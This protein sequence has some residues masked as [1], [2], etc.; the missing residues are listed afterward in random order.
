MK[1]KRTPKYLRGSSKHDGRY[2]DFVEHCRYGKKPHYTGL[3]VEADLLTGNCYLHWHSPVECRIAGTAI[4][5]DITHQRPATLHVTHYYDVKRICRLCKQ[6]FIFF[7]QEQKHWYEEL[8]FPLEV[9]SVVCQ[10]C[11]RKQR[12]IAKKRTRYEEL[13]HI[14]E[15]TAEETLEMA[16][17]CV[18]LIEEKIFNEGKVQ[19]VRRLLKEAEGFNVK[20]QEQL[21]S[22]IERLPS[23]AL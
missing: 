22:R 17:C 15:R 14:K 12:G 23:T 5:A 3:D 2:D 10:P 1:K 18:T 20:L 7:A 9:D 4:P 11:R 6:P 21:R 19:D 16:E 8:G 13:F